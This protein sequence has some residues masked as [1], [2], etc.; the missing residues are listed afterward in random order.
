MADFLGAPGSNWLLARFRT[1]IAVV[2][3]QVRATGPFQYPTIASMYLEIAF[4][5]GLGLLVSI[6]AAQRGRQLLLIAGLALMCEAIVFTFTRSGLLTVALSLR[7]CR[8]GPVV[9]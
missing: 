7:D 9:A 3:A 1:G 8:R 4:A 6:D 2:G 5:A